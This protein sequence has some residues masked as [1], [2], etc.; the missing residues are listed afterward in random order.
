MGGT[1]LLPRSM[2]V[3][4]RTSSSTLGRRVSP[5]GAGSGGG[6]LV[7]GGAVARVCAG[8]GSG[9]DVVS[10]SDSAAAAAAAALVAACSSGVPTVVVVCP[11]ACTAIV[12]G[13]A[14]EVVVAPVRLVDVAGVDGLSEADDAA[15]RPPAA[16]RL[17]SGAWLDAPVRA[18]S[19]AAAKARVTRGSRAREEIST[20]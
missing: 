16:V 3:R 13:G 9:S 18:A 1:P 12:T 15:N 19:R 6:G 2:L 10:G 17:S 8:S 4:V 5:A 20:A 14:H 11:G 7:G